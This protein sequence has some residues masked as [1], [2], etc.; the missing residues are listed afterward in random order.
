MALQRLLAAVGTHHLTLAEDAAIFIAL[1]L[2]LFV[3]LWCVHD[4]RARA[5]A[6]GK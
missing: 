1:G 6:K 2:T 3:V 4:F 5:L